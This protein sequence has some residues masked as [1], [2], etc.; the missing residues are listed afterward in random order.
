MRRLTRRLW[1]GPDFATC[2]WQ[3]PPEQV[4][5]SAALERLIAAL[6]AQG[7]VMRLKGVFHTDRGW[8]AV[9]ADADGVRWRPSAWRT[10]SRLEVIAAAEG[11]PD[12]AQV[13]ALLRP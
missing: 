1:S 4:F 7:A 10:D 9:Q 8:R 2:G 6:R 5:S 11:A 13:E 3:A 12:W